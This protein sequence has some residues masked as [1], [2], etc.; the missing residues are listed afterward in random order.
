LFSLEL[1]PLVTLRFGE[2]PAI[3]GAMLARENIF[4]FMVVA[5][6]KGNSKAKH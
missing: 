2:L 5:G 3:M 4:S 1:L 6:T